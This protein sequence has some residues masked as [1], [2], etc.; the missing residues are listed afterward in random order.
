MKFYSQKNYPAEILR[1]ACVPCSCSCQIIQKP[2]SSLLDKLGCMWKVKIKEMSRSFCPGRFHN[3]VVWS[4]YS[5]LKLRSCVYARTA[6]HTV[7][8]GHS[9]CQSFV[10]VKLTIFFMTVCENKIF[11]QD[12]QG[13]ANIFIQVLI[14]LFLPAAQ[15][16]KLPLFIFVIQC[17]A[18][19]WCI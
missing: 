5:C 1:N 7:S 12:L 17:L 13:G 10:I 15:D 19:R 3:S 9:I 4:Q 6:S 14:I 11:N 2:S 18:C 16:W 8:Q